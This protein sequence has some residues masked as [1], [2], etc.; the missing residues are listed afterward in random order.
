MPR[1]RCRKL[2][3]FFLKLVFLLLDK[4]NIKPYGPGMSEIAIR[5]KTIV[6]EWDKEWH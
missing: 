5:E 4:S 6:T 2:E 1:E 3:T